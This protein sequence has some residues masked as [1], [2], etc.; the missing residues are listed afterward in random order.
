[1][2]MIPFI[3]LAWVIHVLV[4]GALALPIVYLGRKRAHWRRW[5]SLAFIGP[6]TVWMLLMMSE[7]ATGK[8]TLSNLLVEP[9]LLGACVALG[10]LIRLGAKG[11]NSAR[12]V[13]RFILAGLCL[14]A[15][16]LFWTVPALPE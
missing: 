15:A 14:L 16:G 7:L 12:Q 4:G 13:S 5:E 9:G 2:G 11:E 1:M 10:A 6:F 3:S 8:K